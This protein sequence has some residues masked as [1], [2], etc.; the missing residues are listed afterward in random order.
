M[1]ADGKLN[2]KGKIEKL[3]KRDRSS[4]M[5][6]TC[7]GEG[8]WTVV[9]SAPRRISRMKI[10]WSPIGRKTCWLIGE[11]FVKQK[12]DGCLYRRV[13]DDAKDMYMARLEAEKLEGLA[14]DEALAAQEMSS[15]EETDQE[16]PEQ[17]ELPE[18][19]D[20]VKEPSGLKGIAHRRAKR[21]AVKLFISHVWEIS[22]RL[23]GLPIRR[24]YVIEK[25]GHSSVIEP[26]HAE[27]IPSPIMFHEED[28]AA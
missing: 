16:T 7:A 11:S 22:R 9:S 3:L 6:G 18:G 12:A 17:E 8:D 21:K 4:Y 28:K 2:G 19:E 26:P 15:E 1:K 14:E 27:N 24:A 23:A 20:R 25:L 10:N 5:T 13:Y